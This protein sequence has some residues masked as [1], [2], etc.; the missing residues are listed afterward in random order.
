M[1]STSPLSS[2]IFESVERSIATSVSA[3]Q[4]RALAI[5]A[6]LASS[7]AADRTRAISAEGAEV[8]RATG[9]EGSLAASVAAETLRATAAEA[10]VAARVTIEQTRAMTA[11]SAEQTRA[12]ASEGSLALSIFGEVFRAQGAE[13]SIAV[14]VFVEHT[15]A[16]G[17][18]G[19]VSAAVSSEQMRATNAEIALASTLSAQLASLQG[20]T[21]ASLGSLTAQ[22]STLSQSTSSSS[23]SAA[24]AAA[25]QTTALQASIASLIAAQSS[26]QVSVITLQAQLTSLSAVSQSSSFSA[27]ATLYWLS[28][29]VVVN[30]LFSTTAPTNNAPQ[31][32]DIFGVGFQPFFNSRMLN[33]FT[34]VFT[35]TQGL[36]LTLT[37]TGNVVPYTDGSGTTYGVQCLS[38]GLEVTA[39]T[40]FAITLLIASTVPQV[41]PFRGPTGR[42][43]ITFLMTWQTATVVN[44][45]VLVSGTGFNPTRTYRCIYTGRD[46]VNALLVQNASGIP[47]STTAILCG[48]SQRAFAP[49]VAGLAPV[50]LTIFEVGSDYEVFRSP[51]RSQ[52]TV[53]VSSCTNG[54]RDGDETD[55]DCGGSCQACPFG[56]FCTVSA[57]CGSGP[58][59][60]SSCLICR[61]DTTSMFRCLCQAGYVPTVVNISLPPYA[62]STCVPQTCPSGT[63]GTNVISGCT[64]NTPLVGT[65]TPSLNAPYY[66]GSC[67]TP[68]SC[69]ALKLLNPSIASGVY[70]LTIPGFNSGNA[71]N[72]YCDFTMDGGLGYAIVFNR[73][74]VTYQAGPSAAE[75]TATGFSGTPG[76]ANDFSLAPTSIFAA[77]GATRMAVYAT[78]GQSSAGG[79]QSGSTY[80]WVRFI[81]S[82]TQMVNCW[83]GNEAQPFNSGHIKL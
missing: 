37:T 31:T 54:V 59:A 36:N 38:P 43:T 12:V 21:Q 25:A 11:E 9:I 81:M 32:V 55:V 58:C 45:S 33:I 46:S 65:T 75:M 40:T 41:V 7:A 57:G 56:R 77:Y 68:R 35:A 39:P 70:S 16:I 73:R 48:S 30:T 28:T 80:R 34:C 22:L 52:T 3:E 53:S 18:E 50:N 24:V 69:A 27:S 8:T 42:D 13:S 83:N 6:S 20:S 67:T 49:V 72:V 78:I 44:S 76:I 15:R 60:G 82:A 2:S 62:T 64:C 5:E 79:V 29:N 61:T 17:A 14:S 47:L 23:Q 66:T 26:L 1:S 74:F 51:S 4:L 10:S 63:T 71:F 19:A